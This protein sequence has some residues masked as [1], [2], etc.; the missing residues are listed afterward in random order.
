MPSDVK[1]QGRS[2]RTP[3]GTI[4][5]IDSDREFQVSDS[6][7]GTLRAYVPKPGRNWGVKAKLQVRIEL[8]FNEESFASPCLFDKFE[9]L[10][11]THKPFNLDI[12]WHEINEWYRATPVSTTDYVVGLRS[13]KPITETWAGQVKIG[14]TE[15]QTGFTVNEETGSIKFDQPLP[16]W[17]EVY[18]KFKWVPTCIVDAST[19]TANEGVYGSNRNYYSGTV[20]LRQLFH[21]IVSDPDLGEDPCLAAEVADDSPT[22]LGGPIP[23][24]ACSNG[25]FERDPIAG[26]TDVAVRASTTYSALTDADVP[27]PFISAGE[28]MV[29]FRA[30]DCTG[31]Y[32][33]TTV[34]T[35]S[36]NYLL[37]YLFEG[38]LLP[39]LARDSLSRVKIGS[40]GGQELADFSVNTFDGT[41]E[42]G[43]R[44]PENWHEMFSGYDLSEYQEGIRVSVSFTNP[45]GTATGSVLYNPIRVQSLGVGSLFRKNKQGTCSEVTEDVVLD[46][47]AKSPSSGQSH[48]AYET[49]LSFSHS[50]VAE[51]SS[52]CASSTMQ[53][54]LAWI[55]NLKLTYNGPGSPPDYVKFSM[56]QYRASIGHT[57]NWPINPPQ[58]NVQLSGP[59]WTQQVAD[60]PSSTSAGSTGS[61]LTNPY[62]MEFNGI[63][64][65]P[66]SYNVSGFHNRYVVT[67]SAMVAITGNFRVYTDIGVKSFTLRI[68]HGKP[69]PTCPIDLAIDEDSVSAGVGGSAATVGALLTG[70]QISYD[71]FDT[72]EITRGAGSG[73]IRIE[74]ESP[75]VFAGRGDYWVCGVKLTFQAR[76]S[77][78]TDLNVDWSNNGTFGWSDYSRGPTLGLTTEWQEF[79]VGGPQDMIDMITATDPGDFDIEEMDTSVW[80]FTTASVASGEI[81]ELRGLR[82]VYYVV[83]R[84]EDI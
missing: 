74:S 2:Y 78:A 43:A 36:W 54:T 44:Y 33:P 84:G 79:T 12:S 32:W 51:S 16:A 13:I 52:A 45:N 83:P 69:V 17:A 4:R 64:T 60:I 76:A 82:A 40:A 19:L 68:Y 46:G 14:G 38:R 80:R 28:V 66:F 35:A 22:V 50:W 25:A 61:L 73:M 18:I 37:Q 15:I 67:S 11:T 65:I 62:R 55:R 39:D 20:V 77:V 53:I 59:S 8:D 70:P 48:P 9:T 75:D 81:L 5:V 63:A 1:V 58:S 47:D 49:R 6:S 42:F 72:Y 3:P 7:D 71:Q 26:Y 23:V 27:C 29:G 30:V 10:R 21:T 24:P 56:F 41:R 57:G 31:F 34:P